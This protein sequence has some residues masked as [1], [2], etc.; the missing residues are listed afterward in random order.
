MRVSICTIHAYINSTIKI[1]FYTTKTGLKP[2]SSYN[3]I[4]NNFLEKCGNASIS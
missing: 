4:S 3:T 2:Y 1:K